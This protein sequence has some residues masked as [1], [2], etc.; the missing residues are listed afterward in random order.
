MSLS[1]SGHSLTRLTTPNRSYLYSMKARDRDL[2]LLTY[3]ENV[4]PCTL[5]ALKDSWR[6]KDPST[7]NYKLSVRKQY[8]RNLIFVANN[9]MLM[10]LDCRDPHKAELWAALICR[11]RNRIKWLHKLTLNS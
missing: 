4:W 10:C 7:V 5:I 3:L 11:L 8:Y 9:E 1:G 2:I 6:T